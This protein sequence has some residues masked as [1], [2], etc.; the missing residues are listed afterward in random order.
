MK[1]RTD[2]RFGFLY[3]KLLYRRKFIRTLWV[4]PLILLPFFLPSNQEFLGVPREGYFW[5]LVVVLIAQAGY[6]YYKWQTE[7]KGS[8]TKLID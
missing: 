3:S 8:N 5:I 6:T 4:S 7:E 2:Q 1:Q